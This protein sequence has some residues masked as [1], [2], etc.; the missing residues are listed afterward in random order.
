MEDFRL[1]FFLVLVVLLA[2]LEFV[3][4]LALLMPFEEG[5]GHG[6]QAGGALE[7][8]VLQEVGQKGVHILLGVHLEAD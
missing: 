7:A 6:P 8:H 4:L 5:V 1:V 2:L 3:A